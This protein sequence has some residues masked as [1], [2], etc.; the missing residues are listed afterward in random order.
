MIFLK[1]KLFLVV[2]A[3]YARTFLPSKILA[4]Y[5]MLTSQDLYDDYDNR[6]IRTG[7]KKLYLLFQILFYYL[8]LL[9]LYIKFVLFFND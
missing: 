3:E 2:G 4:F 7:G 5:H 1:K 8:S 6:I 9:F